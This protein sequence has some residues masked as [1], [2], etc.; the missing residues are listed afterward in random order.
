MTNRAAHARPLERG[1][2]APLV[3][4][5]AVRVSSGELASLLRIAAMEG[6][7]AGVRRLLSELLRFHGVPRGQRVA[8]QLRTLVQLVQSLRSVAVTDELTG[9]Y[10]R[11]GFMQVGTRLLDVAIRDERPVHLI[12]LQVDHLQHTLGTLGRSV[13][14]ALL[15]ETANFMRDLCPGYGVYE[16]L[17]R[18]STDQFAALTISELY[19]SRSLIQLH[20]SR[21]CQAASRFPAL[22]LSVGVAHFDP[23]QP[24]GIDELLEHAVRELHQ[25][26]ETTTRTDLANCV[27]GADPPPRMTLDG[28]RAADAV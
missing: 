1:P 21:S 24:V 4:P 26:D 6:D 17:G 14:Y 20:A 8:L 18:V 12:C 5:R 9:L 23:L 16:V 19:P 15:R 28:L 2:A 25:H 3:D 13:A 22:S 7:E 10:N 11:R 27:A